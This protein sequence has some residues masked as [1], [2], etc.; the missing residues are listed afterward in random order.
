MAKVINLFY[1]TIL[2]LSLFF[3]AMND[4][5]KSFFIILQFYSLLLT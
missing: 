5:G 4:A 3:I 2:F 1:I